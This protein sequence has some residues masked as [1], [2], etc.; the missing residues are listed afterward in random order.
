[1]MLLYR[2]TLLYRLC[3]RLWVLCIGK[4][5]LDPIQLTVLGEKTFEGTIERAKS[6]FCPTCLTIMARRPSRPREVIDL[7]SSDDDE[8]KNGDGGF[9]VSAAGTSKAYKKR[10]IANVANS[11]SESQRVVLDPEDNAVVTYGLLQHAQAYLGR[12][13]KTCLHGGPGRD[14]DTA[15]CCNPASRS[16]VQHF[17]QCGAWD[18]GFRN[19][20][21][22]LS[23]IIPHAKA[24]H[25]IFQHLPRRQPNPTVPSLQQI[26]RAMEQA[27][28]SGFDPKGAQHYGHRM[29]DQRSWIGAMEVATILWSWGVDT[30]VIQFIHCHE[31]RDLLPKFVWAYFSKVNGQ[32]GCPHSPTSVHSRSCAEALLE[33]APMMNTIPVEAACECPLLPLYLQW[34]V[35]SVTIVGIEDDGTLLVYDPLKKGQAMMNDLSK[36]ATA[37]PIH[38]NSI[39]RIS[40]KSLLTHDTQVVL[41]TLNPMTTNDKQLCKGKGFNV[42]TAAQKAV[43]WSRKL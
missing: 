5:P 19:L 8:N 17:Q 43:D 35:H 3:R 28:A 24:S 22:M 25:T 23:A 40:T 21:M 15:G 34:E 1:M 6:I 42:L 29:V 41:C 12:G 26:Q 38:L 4:L 18:C 2:H 14:E 39:N 10:K 36:E 20:Q 13:T 11:Y 32:E 16:T 27:W 9:K 7:V 37:R 30:T 33:W 31:S